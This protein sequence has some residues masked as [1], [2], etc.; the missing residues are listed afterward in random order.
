M[1]IVESVDDKGRPKDSC[2][3]VVRFARMLCVFLQKYSKVHVADLFG[4]SS[5][6]YQRNKC[7]SLALVK[8]SVPD[9]PKVLG[10]KV[11]QYCSDN[12]L[13]KVISMG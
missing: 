1:T 11:V 10:T 2:T 7:M 5:I 6:Y 4:V 13:K 3:T 8:S 9:A 12:G